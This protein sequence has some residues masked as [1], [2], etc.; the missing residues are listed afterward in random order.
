MTTTVNVAIESQ[1]Q[2]RPSIRLLAL[3][4]GDWLCSVPH[5]YVMEDIYTAIRYIVKR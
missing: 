2:A 1:T 3:R 5:V 4:G